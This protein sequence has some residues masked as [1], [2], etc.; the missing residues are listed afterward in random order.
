[1]V[2]LRDPE[3]ANRFEREWINFELFSRDKQSEAIAKA[4]KPQQEY[5]HG[6]PGNYC[7]C[8]MCVLAKSRSPR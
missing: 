8:Y 6:L 3:L 7:H 2:D 4:L 1:M 5:K